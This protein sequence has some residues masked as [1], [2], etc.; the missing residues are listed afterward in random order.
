MT[1]PEL[2]TKAIH[3]LVNTIVE[4]KEFV[5]AQMPDILQQ[6]LIYKQIQAIVIM[7]STFITIY[8][9]YKAVFRWS[10]QTPDDD[11]AWAISKILCAGAGLVGSVVSFIF[12]IEAIQALLQIWF[13]PKIVIL[14]ELSKLV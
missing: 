1:N 11:G 4:S 6:I 10:S 5:I 3:A 13:S 12:I 14:K 9:S 8:L 7:I 2:L